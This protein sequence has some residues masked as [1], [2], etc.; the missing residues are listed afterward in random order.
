VTSSLQT[1]DGPDGSTP[2][3]VAGSRAGRLPS[4]TGMRFLCAALVFFFHFAVLGFFTSAETSAKYLGAVSEGGLAGV[5]Y[6]FILSGFV[7][8]WSAR[9]GDRLGAFWRRRF[10]KIYP[11]Y[12]VAVILGILL[13]VVIQ[14]QAFNRNWALLD[15]FLVQS[16]SPDLVT[17]SGF[18]APLWSLSVEA[19]FYL[20]F[21][22]LLR[23]IDRI[24]P[25]RLWAWAAGLVAAVFVIP[26]VAHALPGNGPVYDNG[27][28]PTEVWLV[29]HIPATRMLEFVLGIV[30]ARI[31]MTGRR[32]PLGLGGAVAL[33]VAAYWASTYLPSR[34]TS[35][36]IMVLPLALLIAAAA[37]Q[38]SEE[39]PSLVSG[40]LWVW[41]GEISYAFYLLHFLVL[42]YARHL[43]GTRTLSS[44]VAFGLLAGCFL[45]TVVVS[46]LLHHLVERPMMAH[47]A[48]SRRGRTRSAAAVELPPEPALAE[49]GGTAAGER[50]AA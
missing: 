9:A 44:P 25:E 13:T 21:P 26:F 27:M 17:R 33:G 36:A 19:L 14:G 10:V 49:D 48:G 15:V 8:T 3:P 4:L 28:T 35:V 1:A 16:W 46:A 41:L 31:V 43:L 29:I 40:R 24:R 6:F 20:S 7:L 39:R 11:N 34:F 12:L 22:L 30:M 38:D 47:F 32:L 5:V 50:R 18:N 42:M 23:L 37:A 2:R 45:A